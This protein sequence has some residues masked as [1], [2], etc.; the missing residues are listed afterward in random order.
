[1]SNPQTSDDNFF[2][3]D[4]SIGKLPHIDGKFDFS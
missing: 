1:M 3:M 4:G 2:F